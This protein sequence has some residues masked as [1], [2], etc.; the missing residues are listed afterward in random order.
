MIPILYVERF[1]YADQPHV[2]RN[3]DNFTRIYYQRHRGGIISKL[4]RNLKEKIEIVFFILLLH[5][6]IT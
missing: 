2:N 1:S 4:N 5:L 6:Y 3:Y